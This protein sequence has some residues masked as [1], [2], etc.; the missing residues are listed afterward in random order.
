MEQLSRKLNYQIAGPYKI[1]KKIGNL[2]KVK[3]LNSVKVHSVFSLDKLRKAA[4][5]PLPGQVNPPPLPIQVSGENEWE[6]EEILACKLIRGTLKYR[7]SWKGYDPDPTWYP[8]WNFIGSP[9][10]LQ[11]F[12]S[13]YPNKP[14]PPKYLNKWMECWHNKDNKLPKEHKDKNTPQL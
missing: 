13:R 14:G 1:L 11:E 9:H 4:T 7:V 10:K 6:I 2:Y 12:H 5:D 8:A 3:L